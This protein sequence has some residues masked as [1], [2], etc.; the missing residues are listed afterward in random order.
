MIQLYQNLW[1]KIYI[2]IYIIYIYIMIKI[3]IY[4]YIYIYMYIYIY[5]VKGRIIVTGTN[6]AN[7]RSKK[8]TFKNNVPFRLCIITHL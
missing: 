2:Y 7:K 1:Q 4:I 6:N 3:Y 8:L 5:V